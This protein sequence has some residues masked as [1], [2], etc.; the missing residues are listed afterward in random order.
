MQNGDEGLP[1]ITL[2]GQDL[3]VKMLIVRE[4]RGIFK[5]TLH[6]NTF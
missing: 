4:P 1:S 5:Q 6:A 3:S 2:A